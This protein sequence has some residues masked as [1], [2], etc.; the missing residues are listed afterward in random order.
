MKL[1]KNRV[2]HLLEY[3]ILIPGA[4]ILLC[5]TIGIVAYY[6]MQFFNFNIAQRKL[7]L[8]ALIIFGAFTGIFT[9]ISF[10]INAIKMYN[11]LDNEK[12]PEE[13]KENMVK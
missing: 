3:A 4:G 7:C 8:F 2:S 13:I 5:G 6:F 9:A 11:I 10:I 12:K 1:D